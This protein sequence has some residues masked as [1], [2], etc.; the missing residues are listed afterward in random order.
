MT[1]AVDDPRFKRIVGMC[2]SQMSKTD[3]FCLNVAGK[4][5]DDDP[6]PILYIGPTRSNVDSVIEP[7]VSQ[8]FKSSESLSSKLVRGR[9]AKKLVKRIAGVTFRLAWAGS[10]TELAS[11]PACIVIVD[12]VDRMESISGE[13]DPVTLAEARIATYPD[14][15]ILIDSTP[16]VGTVKTYTHPVTGLE[17]WEVADPEDVM[18]PVWLYWQEGT[19]QEWAVPCKE[20]RQYFIPRFKLL[21]WGDAKTPAEASRKARLAC[22]R[23]G[24]AH[25]ETD[26]PSMNAMGRF[27][28]PGQYVENGEVKGDLID[29][30]CAS[31]WISGL[32]SPW[33]SFGESA[34]KWLSAVQS[35]DQGR[36]QAVINTR[37]GELYT[38]RGDAPE[39]TVVR[40]AAESY[41]KG[42][43]LDWVQRIYLTVDV[44][45]DRLVYNFRGWG[46]GFR[47]HLIEDG[48]IW[49]DTDKPEVWEKLEKEMERT[50]G[51]M[52]VNATAVDSGYR[53]EMVY[54][55]CL[56]HKTKAFATKGLDESTKL[57]QAT[58]VEV[59]YKGKKVPL[60]LKLWSFIAGHFKSWVHTRVTW[61]KDKPGYWLVYQDISEEYCKQI[62]AEHQMLLPSGKTKWVRASKENHQFDCEVLQVLLAH[63][64]DVRHLIPKEEQD[65][66]MSISEMAKKLNGG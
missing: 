22:S 40:G 64:L 53:S 14:G 6:V 49:G 18:S 36:V 7:R 1:E 63:M 59:N 41:Q 17:H 56:K 44:Q 66:K 26:K 11:Q 58:D 28:G 48:N 19:R 34:K 62:V 46:D 51:G 30:D 50:F 32:M 61:P 42:K 52:P 8:M 47:S 60:A 16:T 33:V 38:S 43:V 27:V 5:L 13:G 2:G 9:K 3:G 39:W 31:F 20:C 57:F 15:K 29:T 37:F 24:S 65:K 55:F 12:E 35:K 10:A 25:E 45:M 23:C 54:Q 4:R 21:T